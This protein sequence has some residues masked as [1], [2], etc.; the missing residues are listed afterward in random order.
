[1]GQ[2]EY[3][4]HCT[5]CREVL[6]GYNPMFWGLCDKCSRRAHKKILKDEKKSKKKR[7][8]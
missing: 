7:K 4:T 5:E 1:M 8:S 3:P 6:I 2:E